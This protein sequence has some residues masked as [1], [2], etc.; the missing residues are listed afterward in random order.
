MQLLV[1]QSK[2]YLSVSGFARDAVNFAKKLGV[3]ILFKRALININKDGRPSEFDSW[4]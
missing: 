2:G 1:E 4:K 3:P